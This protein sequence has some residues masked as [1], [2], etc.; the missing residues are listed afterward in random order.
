ME[1]REIK[2]VQVRI[3]CHKWS[4][5]PLEFPRCQYVTQAAVK[6]DQSEKTM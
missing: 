4:L 5:L 1:K 3:D 6:T 2:I